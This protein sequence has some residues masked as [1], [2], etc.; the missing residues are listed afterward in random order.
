MNTASPPRSPLRLAA[1]SLAAIA[2]AAILLAPASTSAGDPLP[3]F[4]GSESYQVQK[5][6]KKATPIQISVAL[7]QEGSFAIGLEGESLL[8]ML[9][10]T[11]RDAQASLL[12]GQDDTLRNV[13]TFDLDERFADRF[14]TKA[15]RKL[16]E[17]LESDLTDL[18]G[19]RTELQAQF[20]DLQD[21]IDDLLAG[22]G[23]IPADL[24]QILRDEKSAVGDQI[25]GADSAVSALVLQIQAERTQSTP[26]FE[27]TVEETRLALR[28]NG[29]RTKVKFKA[30]VDFLARNRVDGVTRKGRR[31]ISGSGVL[32]NTF[33]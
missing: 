8:G 24:L 29:K 25:A 27:V 20:D 10:G 6:F 28:P 17:G 22:G 26:T 33:G 31:K 9:V 30:R 3:T 14:R 32:T 12:P 11:G 7:S 4:S 23:I 19:R 2:A 21:R 5:V 13:I 18:T 16:L 15:A 1:N